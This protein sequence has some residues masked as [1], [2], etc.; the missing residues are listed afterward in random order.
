M[1]IDEFKANSIQFRSD[2]LSERA[3]TQLTLGKLIAL[4][5]DLPKNKTVE[6][7]EDGGSYRG[8]Y[9]DLA[10]STISGGVRTVEELS[11]SLKA[12]LGKEFQGWE[13]GYFTMTENTPLWAAQHG[14]LGM[15]ITGLIEK[16]GVYTFKLEE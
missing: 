4:L 3:K 1:T 13:G 6:L 16:D 14:E 7:L 10:F 5:E 15:R 8:Y 2:G 9:S 11:N 12:Y